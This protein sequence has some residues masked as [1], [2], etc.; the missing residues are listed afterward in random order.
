MLAFVLRAQDLRLVVRLLLDAG[1]ALLLPALWHLVPLACDAQAWR[2]VLVATRAPVGFGLVLRARWIDES[3]NALLPVMSVGG[4][5]ARIR[6]LSRSGVS[7]TQGAASAIVDLT[8]ALFAE[9]AFVACGLAALALR[10]ESEATG[11]LLAP[12]A[13]GA[14]LVLAVGAT[15]W[16]VLRRGVFRAAGRLVNRLVPVASALRAGSGR[17]ERSAD[18]HLARLDVLVRRIRR[19]R[20]ALLACLGWRAA[21]WVLGSVETWLALRVLGSPVGAVQAFAIE[22][23]A[24]ALRTAGFAVPGAIGV[25]EGGTVLVGR[26]FGLEDETALALA[27]TRRVRELV[28]GLPGLVTWHALETR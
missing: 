13:L 11:R 1:P 21:A 17:A 8:L 14:A 10:D 19:E 4:I 18:T 20:S 16:L 9:L 26:A 2:V 7:A 25:H 12:L 23:L 5:V 15:A 27:L 22:A 6:V 28:L 3:V 24:Q